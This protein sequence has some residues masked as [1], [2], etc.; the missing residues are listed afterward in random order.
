MLVREGV[1]RNDALDRKLA[2]SLAA[3]AGALNAAAFYAVGFFSANMT[4][5]VSALSDHLALAGWLEAGF[6]LS[7]V[8]A[9]IAGS[10]VSA[11]LVSAGRRRRV[12]RI[13]GY[14]I[15]VEALLLGL[16]G[17]ATLTP[18]G[19]WRAPTLVTGLA[20][21]LGLQNAVVTRISGARVRTTHVSG[22]VT[23]LGIELAVAYDIWRG[24]ES[25]VDSADNASKL[26]LHLSTIMAFLVGGVIGVL[27]YRA[28]GN[29]LLFAGA[30]VLALVAFAGISQAPDRT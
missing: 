3:V 1:S 5:N 28:I 18:L 20:F 4:G 15:L 8:L 7:V 24:R 14:V 17:C 25:R 11:L 29:Y 19:S 12:H 16:L 13:Y 30:G 9:F 26:W 2:A 23:D 27:I 10:A 21:L 6:Y 22:M